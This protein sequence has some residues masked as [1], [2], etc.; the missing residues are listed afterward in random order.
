MSALIHDVGYVLLVALIPLILYNI[1]R[2]IWY[3]TCLF[4]SLPTQSSPEDVFGREKNGFFRLWKVAST[5]A[6]MITVSIATIMNE[7]PAYS[8]ALYAAFGSLI[9][10]GTSSFFYAIRAYKRGLSKLNQQS[11]F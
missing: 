9:A 6:V 11:E 1:D 10:F 7:S 2:G 3:Q 5:I 4:M 8:T